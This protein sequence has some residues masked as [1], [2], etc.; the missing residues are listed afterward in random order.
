MG[1]ILLFG[2]KG[3]MCGLIKYNQSNYPLVY[4]NSDLN[5]R[6]TCIFTCMCMSV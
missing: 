6:G 1:E 3:A 2:L 4:Y 5:K